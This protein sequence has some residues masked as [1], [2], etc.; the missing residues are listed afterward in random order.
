MDKIDRIDLGHTYNVDETNLIRVCEEDRSITFFH[1]R[2][3]TWNHQFERFEY[4]EFGCASI[5]VKHVRK[6]QYYYWIFNFA[7]SK[8]DM[9]MCEAALLDMTAR[10][11]PYGVFTKARKNDDIF[12]HLY[13]SIHKK[14]D[15]PLRAAILDIKTICL[16][17][18]KNKRRS[19][20]Q[21]VQSFSPRLIS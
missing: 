2:P 21:P 10:Y 20:G 5:C 14:P 1:L 3:K 19:Y 4:S 8:F 15:C 9:A 17:A 11:S 6:D 13:F 16:T 18:E 7:E 12:E